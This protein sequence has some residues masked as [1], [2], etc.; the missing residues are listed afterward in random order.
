MY[1]SD[2]LTFDAADRVL[3]LAPH[4]D[5]ETIATGGIIQ[6]AVELGLPVHLVYLTYGDNNETAF[7]VYRKRPVV[8]GKA[9]QQMGLVR[10]DEALAATGAL[11]LRPDQVTFLGYP[12][13]R[14]LAIWAEHWGDCPPCMSM[15]TRTDVV[16][17][18]NALR[19]GT[20][21]RADE[22]LADVERMLR[23]FRPTK[24]FVAHPADHNP[25]HL[26]LYLFTRV[27]LWNLADEIQPSVYPF[28]VHHPA[29]P[30]PSG[31]NP[32]LPLEPPA[33]LEK[34]AT[35]W[36]HGLTPAEVERKAAALQK[37]QT[38]YRVSASYLNSFMRSNEL[39]GDLPYRT[40]Q[41][42][43]T[44]ASLSSVQSTAGGIPAE[45]TNAERAKWVGVERRAVWLD[46]GCV[47][48]SVDFSR[49]LGSEVGAQVYLFGYRRDRPFAEMPKL[50]VRLTERGYA[51]QDGLR[52]LPKSWVGLSRGMK[53][54]VLRV[55]FEVLG[56]PRW[57]MGSVRTTV[58]KVPLD[59]IAW[60]T[61]EAPEAIAYRK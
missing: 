53:G 12:D 41:P 2:K 30:E 40:L 36:S 58:R 38:Q 7:T 35:W 23:E 59:W 50:Q 5:D 46:D 44:S 27:A 26:A 57:I 19:P 55:P 13:F 42:L 24:V 45:L 56:A 25:D 10:Y 14:T 16:P 43:S 29:W 51:V 32:G 49:P 1:P 31:L 8:G 4:P 33:R 17:Y 3:I 48:I 34:D 9:V 60:R 15:F 39:F 54:Y 61:V 21:Y 52:S 37:H 47:A 28:L 18:P 22:I 20:P 11:G 6:K